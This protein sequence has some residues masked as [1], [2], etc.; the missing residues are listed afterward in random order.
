MAAPVRVAPGVRITLLANE[1]AASGQP[2]NLDGR[3]LSFSFEEGPKKADQVSLQ[4]DNYD[5]ALEYYFKS[6]GLLSAAV[7]RKEIKDFQQSGTRILPTD[8]GGFGA[9]YAGYEFV[10]ST[11]TG[12]ATVEGYEIAYQQQFTFLPGFLKNFGGFAN[13]THLKAEGNMPGGT[14]ANPTLAAIQNYVPDT[15]NLG[16]TYQRFPFSVRLLGFWRSSYLVAVSPDP[17]QSLYRHKLFDMDLKAEYRLN[18]HIRL[19]CDV[20]KLLRAEPINTE[21]TSDRYYGLRPGTIYRR[22][23]QIELGV[24]ATW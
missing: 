17:S 18:N 13:W 21:G 2:L 22:P 6:T 5:L 11:N 16:L 15:V 9:Q 7:F 14:T 8:G 20:Y 19:F 10:T 3:I 1:K 4:L 24:R 23:I 12:D